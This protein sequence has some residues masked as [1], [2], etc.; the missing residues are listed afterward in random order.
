MIISDDHGASWHIGGMPDAN[1]NENTITA[2]NDTLL[3]VSMR[4]S[5]HNNQRPYC[6][7]VA[8]STDG[9]ISFGAVAHDCDLPDSICQGSLLTFHTD[10]GASILLFSNPASQRR[11]RLTVRASRDGGKTWDAG[12][13][14]YGGSAAYSDLVQI[15]DEMVGLLFERDLYHSITWTTL[16]I[17]E[18]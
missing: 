10:D 4:S 13:L 6:R 7:E 5:G 9:G 16:K 15:D 1:A 18:L 11:E 2:I 8:W 17:K 3:Y 14:I 12:R